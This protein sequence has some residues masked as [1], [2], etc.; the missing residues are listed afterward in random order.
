MNALAVPLIA[1]GGLIQVGG[2]AYAVLGF[3]EMNLPLLVGAL[4]VGT[5]IEM[6]G[7]ALLMASRR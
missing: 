5:M 3:E 2:V 7:V 1:L 4:V 6:G